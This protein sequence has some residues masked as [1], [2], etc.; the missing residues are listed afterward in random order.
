MFLWDKPMAHCLSEGSFKNA[1]KCLQFLWED[2]GLSAIVW[3]H[4]V[5]RRTQNWGEP[6]T[7]QLPV[8]E[9]EIENYKGSFYLFLCFRLTAFAFRLISPL[10][11]LSI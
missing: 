2:S 4:L 9:L 3:Q 1:E 11:F 6:G 5:F 7:T 10:F 8:L